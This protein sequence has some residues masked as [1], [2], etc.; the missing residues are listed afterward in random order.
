MTFEGFM[1]ALDIKK[2][3]LYTTDMAFGDKFECYCPAEQKSILSGRK[4]GYENNKRVIYHKIYSSSHR[5][6]YNLV[7]DIYYR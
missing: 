2:L 6:C 7:L 3:S 5:I 1:G 4:I